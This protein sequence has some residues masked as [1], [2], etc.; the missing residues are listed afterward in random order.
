MF[1]IVMVTNFSG[2]V[3]KTTLTKNLL[4][5]NLPGVKVFAVETVNAGYDQGEAVQ[6]SAEQTRSILEQVIE[7]SMSNPVIVDVGA[8]NVSNFF[9]ALA[10]YDGMHQFIG[11]VLIPTEPSEKV[12]KD[13]LSTMQYLIETLGFDDSQIMLVLNKVPTRRTADSVFGPLLSAAMDLGV[14]SYGEVPE[15]DTFQLASSM[16]KTIHE[17]AAMDPKSILAAAKAKSAEI[18]GQPSAASGVQTML[19]A[20]SAKKL[21]VQLDGIFSRMGISATDE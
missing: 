1:P 19:A 8:S 17:L 14:M 5:P 4:V 3:G 13:T 7:A 18:G 9:A 2:N 20:A 16:G 21:K 10:G 11:R 15:S 12:Q 6:L